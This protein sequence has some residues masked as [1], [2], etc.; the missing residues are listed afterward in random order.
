MLR[1]HQTFGAHTGRVLSV[2]EDVTR[3]GRLP[4]NDVSFDPHAD[5]DAS[6]RHAEI[7]R[8]GQSWV[9]VDVGSRNG[10]LVG[11][12]RVTR[13]VL[14]DGDEIEFGLGGPRVRVEMVHA[15]LEIAAAQG[16]RGWSGEPTGAATPIHHE[17]PPASF[18]GPPTPSRPDAANGPGYGAPPAFP[19]G[20]VPST[21]A[22]PAGGPYGPPPLEPG[23][24]Q[25]GQ[26]TV[27]LMIDA[28]VQQERKRQGFR[29]TGEI[30]ALASEA[31]Q[32]SSRGLRFVVL[33]L[34]MLVLVVF[35]AV[36]G[37]F[38]YERHTEQRLR[39]EN[40][41]L[42]EQLAAL[43]ESDDAERQRLEDRIQELNDQLSDHQDDA[44]AVIAE[45]NAGAVFLLAIAGGTERLHP[46]CSAFAVEPDLLA[47]NAH[48]VGVLERAIGHELRV[49]VRSNG[50]SEPPREVVQMWRHPAYDAAER[51]PT[52]DVGLLRIAPAVSE[53]VTLASV[54]EVEQLRVGEDMF[55]LGFSSEGRADRPGVTLTSG[56]VGRLTAFDG[57]AAGASSRHLLSHSAFADHGSEGAPVFDRR[58][59]VVAINAGN[60]R[61]SQDPPERWPGARRG[62]DT[63]HYAWA[64]RADLLLQL[65]MGLQQQ[66]SGQ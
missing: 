34:T 52:P 24:K 63:R 45:R 40:V 28:A 38:F 54:A 33:L 5:L 16:G 1:L 48:C 8:E 19:G 29:S 6:G 39:S 11:G 49:E 46:V 23:A 22:P 43:G 53:L 59:R 32:R 62:G 15:P 55:V 13:H 12:Q 37:L 7:R 14:A 25:F 20:G 3:F 27:G 18:A 21:P 10:T 42:Q 50:G 44:G 4:D 65:V 31:A 35:A 61:G 57:G 56:V 41:E 51:A 30:R 9:L 36:V 64:V 2:A 26:R 66:E 47:T 58:G 60:H 17:G